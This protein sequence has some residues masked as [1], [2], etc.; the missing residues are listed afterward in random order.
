MNLYEVKVNHDVRTSQ[1][2]DKAKV[3]SLE[4]HLSTM[5]KTQSLVSV[6]ELNEINKMIHNIWGDD[7]L[8]KHPRKR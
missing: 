6:M 3:K 4:S 7:R 2:L 8:L 5:F 1:T